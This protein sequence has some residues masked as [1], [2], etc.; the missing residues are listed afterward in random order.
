MTEGRRGRTGS[1]S[2]TLGLAA[3][4]TIAAVG[5]AP[6]AVQGQDVRREVTLR[7]E[8]A[9]WIGVSIDVPVRADGSL[10]ASAG[11]GLLVSRVMED[12]PADHARLRPGDRIVRVNGLAA[13][14]ERFKEVAGNLRPGDRIQ[15]TYEG[16]GSRNTVTI[17]AAERPDSPVHFLPREMVVRISSK[18][19]SMNHRDPVRVLLAGEEMVRAFSSDAPGTMTPGATLR[20]RGVP[21]A[22]QEPESPPSVFTLVERRDLV[23]GARLTRVG[24]D[25]ATY[26]DVE[27]GLLVTEIIEGTPSTEAGLRPGDVLVEVDGRPLD[28]IEHFRRAWASAVQENRTLVLT[29][30]RRGERIELRLPG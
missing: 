15:L 12:S 7:A 11:D 27:G 21:S 19:D 26:F 5:A 13:T 10:A 2:A 17:A 22:S 23:A 4:A 28:E 29:L 6:G 20:V 14:V 16:D 9:G 8:P 25:L 1:R 3:A 24:A 30:V 18:V